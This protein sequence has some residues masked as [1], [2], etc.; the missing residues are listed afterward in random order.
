MTPYGVGGG[1][2]TYVKD[3]EIIS[4]DGII[5]GKAKQTKEPHTLI[6]VV[7]FSECEISTLALISSTLFDFSNTKML[8]H[9][10]MFPLMA[11]CEK[12]PSF[13]GTRPWQW[14]HADKI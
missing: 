7:Y 5:T 4:M 12:N 1:R 9:E 6:F 13:T 8:W 14:A 11:F 3:R 2:E 10:N